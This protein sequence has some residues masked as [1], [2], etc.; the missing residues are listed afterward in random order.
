MNELSGLPEKHSFERI[1]TPRDTYC[2]V[3]D[4]MPSKGLKKLKR[5]WKNSRDR[6]ESVVFQYYRHYTPDTWYFWT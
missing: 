3:L 5:M 2:N 4:L 6:L 1:N